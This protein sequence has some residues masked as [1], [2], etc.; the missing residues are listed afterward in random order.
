MR[1]LVAWQYLTVYIA[2]Q[3]A[4]QWTVLTRVMVVVVV[5]DRCNYLV[6]IIL[7]RDSQSAR[8]RE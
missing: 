5:V 8:D 1:E 6:N 7:V 3:T 2:L 4:L